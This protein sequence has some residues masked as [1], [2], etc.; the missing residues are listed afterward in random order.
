MILKI[1]INNVTQVDRKLKYFFFFLVIQLG[2]D[3]SLSML[4]FSHYFLSPFEN[5]LEYKKLF[6]NKTFSYQHLF[7]CNSSS[8]VF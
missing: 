6:F 2:V 5:M 8:F 4:S 7:Y 3:I 1:S